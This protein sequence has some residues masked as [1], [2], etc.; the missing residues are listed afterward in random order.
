[1][2]KRRKKDSWGEE[3]QIEGANKKFI[4]IWIRFNYIANFYPV[5]LDAQ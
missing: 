5:Y 1:M 4:R 3:S 2:N